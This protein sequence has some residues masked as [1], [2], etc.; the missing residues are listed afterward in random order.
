MTISFEC[1]NTTHCHRPTYVWEESVLSVK[2]D[3]LVD[4]NFTTAIAMVAT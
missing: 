1:Y 3:F 2:K 4:V